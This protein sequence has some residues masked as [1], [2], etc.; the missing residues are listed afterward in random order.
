MLDKIRFHAVGD[1]HNWLE[2]LII[3]NREH[4]TGAREQ[5]QGPLI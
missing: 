2:T 3:K 5:S 4:W 1:S